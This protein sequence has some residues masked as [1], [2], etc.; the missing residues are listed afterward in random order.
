MYVFFADKE[1]K[2][3]KQMR[4][5]V[6]TFAAS[7]LALG[8]VKGDRMAVW[9]GNHY[10]WL[11]TYYACAL[12]GV[13]VVH[14]PLIFSAKMQLG[15][16]QTV[17]VKGL[18]LTRSPSHIYDTVCEIIP[19]ICATTPETF[20]S[21][22]IPN[23][24]FIISC[25]EGDKR[26]RGAYS[27]DAVIARCTDEFRRHVDE[28]CP[29][30][31]SDDPFMILFT[32]GSTGLPKPVTHSSHALLNNM[33]EA[34]IYRKQFPG[35]E[36]DKVRRYALI[37]PLEGMNSHIIALL[38]V[39]HQCT[40]VACPTYDRMLA[41]EAITKERCTDTIMF[42]YMA[43][44]ILNMPDLHKYDFSSLKNIAVGGNVIPL[45]L[46]ERSK[47][48]TEN[49]LVGYGST[50]VSSATLQHPM[51]PEDKKTSASM[52]PIGGFEVKVC[53]D[54]G[55]VLPVGQ[56]GEILVRCV[57]MF[58]Y[59]WGDEERTRSAKDSN[60]WW[61]SGDI[62]VMDSD[63]FIQLLG[64][65][66][67]TIIKKAYSFFPFEVE[68]VLDEHPCISAVMVVGVPDDRTGEEVCACIRL[69]P[70]KTVSKS[71]LQ[72]YCKGKVAPDLIPEYVLFMEDFPKTETG[73]IHRRK[74]AEFASERVKDQ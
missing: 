33:N 62:G 66:S 22:S 28:I 65:Q 47:Q 31:D 26:Q 11:L 39:L 9:G 55:E 68:K 60:G 63:G 74:L 46:R 25:A 10:E 16:L 35:Y 15:I 27:P 3:Y 18:L 4:K 56:P 12:I 34:G 6:H 48:I 59:Y 57:S 61:H 19:E 70:E 29:T 23:L 13:I 30:V 53:S 69:H 51:D 67:E 40:V 1:R 58:L 36:E 17:G 38:T 52:Y 64:R 54:S 72:D 71:E 14:I 24:K 20:A 50:E 49:I 5:E 37:S 41:V 42:Q 21:Q 7:L 45:S 44:D 43:Y 32:S 2:T 8:L 73:K